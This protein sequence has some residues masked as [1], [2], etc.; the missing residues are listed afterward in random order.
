MH[1][2]TT[3]KGKVLSLPTNCPEKKVWMVST[4]LNKNT[5]NK[6]SAIY[7]LGNPS[8]EAFQSEYAKAL[9]QDLLQKFKSVIIEEAGLVVQFDAEDELK[10][11]NRKL[12]KAQTLFESFQQTTNKTW[13]HWVGDVTGVCYD[14]EDLVD[15]IVLGASKTSVVEKIL[16]FFERRKMAQQILELQDRLEDIINGLDMVNRTNQQAQQCSLGCF[17]KIANVKEQVV[18]PVKLFGRV[19][20]KEKII[21]MLLKETSM[22]SI[23]GMNG[24]GKTTLARSVQ[25]DSRIRMEFHHIVWIS[26]SAEFDMTKVTDFILQRKHECEYRF[27]PENIQ[28]SFDDLYKGKSILFV[29]DD[30]REVK[31]NDWSSFCYYFLCSP[32]CKV[33]LTTSNQNVVS[34]TNSTPYHLHMMRDE[35]CRALIM[36]RALSF[37]NLSERQRASLE[38]IAGALAQKCKGLPL[39]ANILGLL[40][41]SKRDDDDWVTLSER[42]ICELRVFKEEIFPAFRLNNPYLASHLKKCLA[43]CSLFPRDYDFEKDNLVQLWMAEGFLVPQ[44]TTSLEQIGCE[45]FDELLW[46]S[47]FQLSHLGDQEMP[48]YKIHEFIHKFAEFV[49]SDTCFRLEKGECS[50]PWHKKAR[51]LSLLCD[52]IKLAFLKEIEKCDG[53]RTF[54]LLNEGGTQIG[55]VPYSFFQK[56]VRL[57]VLDLSHTNIDAL[58]ESLGRLKY[59]RYLGASKSHIVRLPKSASDLDGLQVLKLRGCSQLLELPKKMKNLTNLVHLDVDI[60]ELRCMPASIGS[61]S[62][63]KTLPAFMVGKKEGYRIIE[64]KNLKNLRGT[65]CLGKLENVKDGGEAMEAMICDKPFLKRLELEWSRCSRDGSKAM[66][67]LAG[68]QPHKNLE[69]LVVINYGGSRFPGWFTSTSC[70]LVNIHVQNCQQ[71]D[72]MPSLG[73]LL[74]LKTLH[75]EGMD[76][77][78]HVDYHFCGEGSN[79]EAFPSLE[80]LK[81]QDMMYLVGWNKLPDNSMSQ[82]RDLIIEECPSL[83]CIQ[84]LN[85]MSSLQSLEINRCT[86]LMSLPELPMSVQSLIIIDSDLVKHR[87]EPEE[88]P[89]WSIIK[90]IPYVEIDFDTVVPGATHHS[91]L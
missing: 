60:K 8:M 2:S 19:N 26:V 32:S 22:V 91:L 86:E 61:L 30:L 17:K 23:V 41:S 55:R 80:S 49:A 62:C 13:Q 85:H 24:L 53:L 72:V 9:L 14:A 76:R 81:I 15:D 77:V 25:D 46:R 11:L 65:I 50:V 36:N 20:D 59:L 78:K 27:L 7:C 43:Y 34:V 74:Y 70:M 68:L 10:K 40:L 31:G 18:F 69:E 42:D 58:P 48:T 67:V 28:S 54:L 1:L 66:D 90:E 75:I 3:L 87:C 71:N 82:L 6:I 21:S 33:L 83:I 16:S 56:L 47:V 5:N 37:N 73:Q 57:R 63:L 39:A 4:F 88:G 64:L 51:H 12:L 89:D 45:Y 44:G 84:S 79:N 29:L 52:S 35:D 38:D